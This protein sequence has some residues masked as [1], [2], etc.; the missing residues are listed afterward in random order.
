[1]PQVTTVREAGKKRYD[2][3]LDNEFA[4]RL[5]EKEKYRY[6]IEE[7]AELPEAVVEEIT[8]EIV[9][10]RARARTLH[11]LQGMD[12]TEFQLRSALKRNGYSQEITERAIDYAKS[13]HYVDDARYARIYAESQS[14]KKSR[15][16]LTQDLIKKGIPRELIEDALENAETQEEKDAI[17]RLLNKRRFDPDTADAKEVQKQYR[18]LMGKG[19]RYDE[20]RDAMREWGI[21]GE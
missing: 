3:Y 5:Y 7:E 14:G 9:L 4:F 6:N 10:K 21:S 16:Q 17:I 18:Y 20:I 19:F 2:I 12:R 11:L 8:E 1:M 15:L 13:F